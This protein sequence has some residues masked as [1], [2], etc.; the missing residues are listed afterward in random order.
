MRD[1]EPNRCSV[2]GKRLPHGMT[3]CG[4]TCREISSGKLRPV[5]IR[6]V[7]EGKR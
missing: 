3:Y 2:C 4:N 6:E 5:S 7:L 1:S